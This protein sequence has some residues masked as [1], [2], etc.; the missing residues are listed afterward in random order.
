[1]DYSD[2]TSTLGRSVCGFQSNQQL[3]SMVSLN[4]GSLGLPTSP[5]Y[6][7]GSA[8]F[9]PRVSFLQFVCHCADAK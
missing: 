4:P 5:S 9:L 8:V 7:L 1:M 2:G 6:L 3:E